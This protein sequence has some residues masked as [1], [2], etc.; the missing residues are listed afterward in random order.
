[1]EET[2][3]LSDHLKTTPT[4]LR[5]EDSLQVQGWQERDGERGRERRGERQTERQRQCQREG[6]SFKGLA[7]S[8][9][10]KAGKEKK[11]I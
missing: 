3:N 7:V 9:M 4:G 5:V 10:S 1:M 11:K 8:E 6:E 2:N